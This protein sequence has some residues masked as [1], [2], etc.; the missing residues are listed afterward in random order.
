MIKCDQGIYVAIYVDAKEREEN[1]IQMAGDDRSPL[2]CRSNHQ[3][4][5]RH[6]VEL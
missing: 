1:G 6:G 5:Q 2:R 4:C 3:G